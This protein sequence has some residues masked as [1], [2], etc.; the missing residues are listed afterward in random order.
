MCVCFIVIFS[1]L[2]IVGR[3]EIKQ[4][5]R[6]L[7]DYSFSSEESYRIKSGQT[8]TLEKKPMHIIHSVI[9]QFHS[10]LRSMDFFQWEHTFHQT[11][12]QQS[13]RYLYYQWIFTKQ[14]SECCVICQKLFLIVTHLAHFGVHLN[15]IRRE[16]RMKLLELT[17][18]KR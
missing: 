9:C 18:S 14:I 13:Q 11:K 3:E 7:L 12:L 10:I 15:E 17:C 4:C 6:H 1:A 5:C 8:S 2:R 16:V